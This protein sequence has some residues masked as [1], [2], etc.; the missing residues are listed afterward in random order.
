MF[1]GGKRNMTAAMG[2]VGGMCLLGQIAGGQSRPAGLPKPVEI[3]SIVSVDLGAAQPGA[4]P[5]KAC[6]GGSRLLAAITAAP[7]G[8][9]AWELR[10]G[11][12]VL[13]RGQ[14]RLDALGRGQASVTL[15]DVLA[16]AEAAMSV[17]SA[18]RQAL[19]RVDIL[20]AAMLRDVRATL[21][22]MELGVMDARGLVQAA[23]KAQDLPFTDLRPQLENDYFRGGIVIL[24][25]FDDANMLADVCNRMAGRVRQGMALV[26]LNPPAGW[27]AMGVKRTELPP[28]AATAELRLARGLCST[29][30]ESDLRKVELSCALEADPN[31]ETLVWLETRGRAKGGGPAAKHPLAVAQPLDKGVV[32]AVTMPQLTDC[33][34]DPVG[35]CML[36]EIVLWIL[37]RSARPKEQR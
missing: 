37:K 15:P 2:L 33:Y 11:K 3:V 21:A 29:V 18:G 23:M 30:R 25:G 32:L 9:A 13:G 27:Q 35:R 24:A 6:L 8:E 34:T 28:Q 20:P 19:R 4:L 22:A 12:V 17:V 14:A 26:V 16:R 31:A 36:S 10:C 7:G 1:G 5:A